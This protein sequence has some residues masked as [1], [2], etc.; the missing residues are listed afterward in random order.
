MDIQH[1]AKIV[2]GIFIMI[3]PVYYR[4]FGNIYGIQELTQLQRKSKATC[5][6]TR[7]QQ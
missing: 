2:F 6:C 3:T 1:T 5:F 4:P 7:E